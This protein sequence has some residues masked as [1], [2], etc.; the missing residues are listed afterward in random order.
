MP[1]QS[2]HISDE[3]QQMGARG[4]ERTD[5]GAS[6]GVTTEETRLKGKTS[7]GLSPDPSVCMG[8]LFAEVIIGASDVCQNCHALIRD[9]RPQVRPARSDVTVDISPYT[10]RR[11]ST[12]LAYPPAESASEA[13]AIFCKCGVE[14]PRTRLWDIAHWDRVRDLIQTTIQTLE[15]KGYDVDREHF[16]ATVL[17]QV[18]TAP[19]GPNE[20]GRAFEAATDTAVTVE[21]EHD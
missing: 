8:D 21:T 16:A 12:V 15:A 2:E 14:H 13:W 9:E 20:L 5:G 4:V 10:R 11:K 18:G 1:K 3:T 6:D 19:V 17:T 7:P